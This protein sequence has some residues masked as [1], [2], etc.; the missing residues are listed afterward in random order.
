MSGPVMTAE[1]DTLVLKHL[2]N[3]EQ[4]PCKYHKVN[5]V[6][7]EDELPQNTSQWRPSFHVIAPA[8]WMND[9][10]GLGYDP[11]TGLYH[12]CFQWNPHGND[13]GNMSWGHATSPDLVSW[14][15]CTEPILTPSAE[16]DCLGVFT[17]CLRATDVA[18][19]PGALTVIYTSVR[20]LPIHFT[21]P[22]TRGSESLSLAVSQDG[23]KTWERQASN[24]F[25]TG[26]PSHLNVTGWRDP[27]ITTWAEGPLSKHTPSTLYGILSGGISKK[28]PTAF[29]YTV[30]E[31]DLSKWHFVGPLVDV[32]LNLRPSRW[33]GDY[34]VNWEVVNLMTLTNGIGT[35]RDFIIMGAEGCVPLDSTARDGPQQARQRRETRAQLWM[36]VKSNGESK[37]TSKDSAL[38]SYAFSGIFDHGCYYAA[39]SF[40]D[41]QTSQHI[42][43]GWITEEDLSNSLR[44]RQGFSGLVSLPRV[45][46]LMTLKDVKKARISQL[47]SI[48]SIDAIPD[49][50]GTGTF[51][52]HTMKISPDSRLTRLRQNARESHL[53]GVVLST[54]PSQTATLLGTSK[55]EIDAE[56]SVGRSCARV[57]IKILHTSDGQ[58]CTTLFW[59][60]RSETFEIHRPLIDYAGVNHGYESAPHT[61]FTSLNE[62]GEEVE[63]TLRVHA[64]FDSSVLEVFVNDRT[65]ISTRIYHPAGQCFGALFF[66]ESGAGTEDERPAAV[67]VRA[68][69]W[70]GLGI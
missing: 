46:G 59:D 21:L 33:S 25:L 44:H 66:A 12:L 1:L 24:P 50:T 15:T 34:G 70:D 8:G 37:S 64:F 63:E 68:S 3:S 62:R 17:G 67:L 30:Q 22:Y 4:S 61:L 57:G 53:D 16:Y 31:S 51:T 56:F 42:V 18:G 35:S 5:G 40:Y 26:P 11:V 49:E 52:I 6:S 69:L 27:V 19:Q 28:T 60:P 2:H 20:H 29:V 47:S 65:V 36:C 14:T 58:D 55:W 54:S 9:P 10:S 7:H 39:N 32:G 45:V 38:A 41:P 43:Y 48:T 13:W 23:G